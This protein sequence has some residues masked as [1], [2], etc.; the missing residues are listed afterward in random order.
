MAQVM[1]Q[2]AWRSGSCWS[3]VRVCPICL[4]LLRAWQAGSDSKEQVWLACWLVV[5]V[6]FFLTATQP[7]VGQ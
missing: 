6:V 7:M 4:Q 3:T 2:L 5:E 1:Q